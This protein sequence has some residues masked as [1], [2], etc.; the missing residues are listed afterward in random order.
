VP[1]EQADLP[2]DF[3]RDQTTEVFEP[4]GC[5]ECRSTGYSGRIG[6]F[7][8]LRTDAMIQRMCVEQRSSTDIRDYGLT[9]GM[10]TLRS[11]GWEQV[12]AGVTSVDEV[13][14]IT[15]GDLVG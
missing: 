15:R 7:E 1:L 13:V 14:R 8:L 5:R 10:T 9:A 3:P 6:V 4:V 2:A 11:S 12:A